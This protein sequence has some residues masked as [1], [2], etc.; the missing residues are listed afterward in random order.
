MKNWS[1]E[2]EDA[3]RF[4]GLTVR[5]EEEGIAE[6]ESEGAKGGRTSD[7]DEDGNAGKEEK[8]YSVYTSCSRS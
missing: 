2:E 3:R 6:K 4:W 8:L 1:W 7:I 5:E